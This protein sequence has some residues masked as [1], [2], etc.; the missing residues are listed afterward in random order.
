[1]MK[2]RSRMEVVWRRRKGLV[3]GEDALQVV[4]ERF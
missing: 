4:F 3:V 1:M 2:P